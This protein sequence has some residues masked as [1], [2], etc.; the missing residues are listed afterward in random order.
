MKAARFRTP[1]VL[2]LGILLG[3]VAMI[4]GV[5]VWGALA[6]FD[7]ALGSVVLRSQA[8]MSYPLPVPDD[9]VFAT[10]V[11]RL[12]PPLPP[13]D[14][15]PRN[16]VL[17]IGDGMGL[18]MV[19]AASALL[20]GPAGGLAFE[21]AQEIGLMKVFASDALVTDSAASATA[22]ATGH[23]TDRKM[24][25]M[26]P[27]GRVPETLFEKARS[28]GLLTGVVTTSGLMDATP[29]GFTAHNEHRNNYAEILTEQLGSGTDVMIGAAWGLLD[30]PAPE[31]TRALDA[32]RERG[33]TIV[34]SA[35]E[36]QSATAPLVA[37]MPPRADSP[38]AGGPPLEVSVRKALAELS[39]NGSGFMLVVESEET[40]GW[41]HAND[42]QRIVAAMAE[43]DAAVREVLLF[44][45]SRGDTLVVVTADH[46]TGGMGLVRGRA[47]E[48]RAQVRWTTD[49]HAGNWVP[50]FA[51]GPGADQFA[52]VLDNTEIAVRIT[53]LLSL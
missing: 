6:R 2:I 20:H 45:D 17:V 53:A 37:L 31:V 9:G 7:V 34:T 22:I 44:A 41:G 49:G 18:G 10:P 48:G 12:R 50:L 13:E 52:G 4:A 16:V 25:S 36:L 26:L 35:E 43:L 11:S 1:V 19:S 8:G 27:D 28:R 15:R 38:D 33:V 23:K 42:V 32:A 30:N 51:F 39:S 47:A 24:V 14:A 46:D 29:A 3:A 21:S 40:D 5:L